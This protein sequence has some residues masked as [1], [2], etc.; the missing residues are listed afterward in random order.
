M[1]RENV[2]SSNREGEESGGDGG[3]GGKQET[4]AAAAWVAVEGR[5]GKRWWD[6]GSPTGGWEMLALQG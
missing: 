3:G 2:N 5:S 1:S 4:I 6:W